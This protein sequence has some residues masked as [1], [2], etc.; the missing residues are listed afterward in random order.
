MKRKPL[1][2]DVLEFFYKYGLEPEDVQEIL[3][4][5]SGSTVKEWVKGYPKY[6]KSQV[7]E[8][9][10]LESKMPWETWLLL[11]A[12]FNRKA[13]FITDIIWKYGPAKTSTDIEPAELRQIARA[14]IE[15][16]IE[17]LRT[18]KYLEQEY[19]LIIKEEKIEQIQAEHLARIKDFYYSRWGF[20]NV[21]VKE[22][23]VYNLMKKAEK[24]LNIESVIILQ[25]LDKLH[26]NNFN[27][28]DSSFVQNLLAI[29]NEYITQLEEA[30]SEN[31]YRALVA[32]LRAKANEKLQ[33]TEEIENR[34]FEKRQKNYLLNTP[35]EKEEIILLKN[36]KKK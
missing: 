14:E 9:D 22:R 6:K 33:E 27:K 34:K 36:P 26:E 29:Y 16:K 30:R 13:Q 20:H 2:K 35:E 25:K 7:F 32:E 12:L 11:N 28:E 31:Y 3:G 8:D 21:R 10:S 23:E 1:H 4:H 18:L 5:S 19:E 17:A 24:E 15:E